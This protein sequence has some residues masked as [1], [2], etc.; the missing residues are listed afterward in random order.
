MMSRYECGRFKSLRK[1]GYPLSYN[2]LPVISG[3]LPPISCP[4]FG[5]TR[6]NRVQN[7]SINFLKESCVP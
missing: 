7:Y 4:T 1:A 6:Y 5:D 2:I 3:A